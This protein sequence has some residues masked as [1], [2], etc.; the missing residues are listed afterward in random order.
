MTTPQP[1]LALD[2][3]VVGAASLDE[4]VRW[5]EATL[6]VAPGPGGRHPL[7]STHNRLLRIATRDFPDAYL[8]LVAIDPD[9][10]DPA[11]ARWF[12]LDDAA[13]RARLRDGPALLH[14]VFRCEALEAQQAAWAAAGFDVGVPVAASRATATGLLS[15]VIVLR[16]DGGLPGDGALPTLIRWSGAHPAAT[17][18][19]AG[20]RLRSLD[21]V[22]VPADAAALLNLPKVTVQCSPGGAARPRWRAVLLGPRGD[23]TLEGR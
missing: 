1:A 11:R 6:G 12:G 8:E 9:A 4:A 5:C 16:D 10:A 17:M 20:L 14:A 15:W 21:F 22:D 18:A 3:L 23:I 13:V 7:M 2:H 19:D